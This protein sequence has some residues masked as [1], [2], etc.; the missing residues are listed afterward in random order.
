MY[1][2]Q[3]ARVRDARNAPIDLRERRA[4]R[5]TWHQRRA[6][7][8]GMALA[9][10]FLRSARAH[11]QRRVR[12]ARSSSK[13][14]SQRGGMSATQLLKKDHETVKGLFQRFDKAGDRAQETKQN[15]VSEI[16]RQLETHTTIEEEIFYPAVQDEAPNAKDVVEE[17]YEEHNVAKSLLRELG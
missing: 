7:A 13:A 14:G 17:A 12:M 1:D 16:E 15:L 9:R 3:R 4:S 10:P 11:A 8:G 5:A 2:A 6:R